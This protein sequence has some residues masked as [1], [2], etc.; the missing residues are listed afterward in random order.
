MW[1]RISLMHWKYSPLQSLKSLT[2]LDYQVTSRVIC[3]VESSG[4]KYTWTIHFILHWQVICYRIFLAIGMK[5]KRRKTENQRT[6]LDARKNWNIFNWRLIFSR[7]HCHH[8]CQRL[9]EK[10]AFIHSWNRYSKT[11]VHVATRQW[12]QHEKMLRSNRKRNYWRV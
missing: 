12:Q 9:Q 11:T 6:I 10:N 2:T 5:S 3:Q 8:E 4:R 7:Q 1:Y